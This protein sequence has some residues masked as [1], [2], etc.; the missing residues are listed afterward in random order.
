M[1]IRKVC[2]DKALCDQRPRL[3][4]AWQRAQGGL[5]SPSGS[6]KGQLFPRGN[7]PESQG[8]ATAGASPARDQQLSRAGVET[9]GS[10]DHK[11]TSWL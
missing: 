8:D 10:P 1:E 11:A 3:L 2:K 9:M 7:K 5:S 6:S 4:G